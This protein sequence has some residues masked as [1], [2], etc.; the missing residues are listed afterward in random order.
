M[1][2]KKT[3]REAFLSGQGQIEKKLDKQ[4]LLFAHSTRHKLSRTLDRGSSFVNLLRCILLYEGTPRVL[5]DV[6]LLVKFLNTGHTGAPLTS[7]LIVKV[8]QNIA[9]HTVS[10]FLK[11]SLSIQ[12]F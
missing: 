12:V 9:I 8:L 1:A 11:P 5:Y 7:Y 3:F 4:N 2:S 10:R 6:S